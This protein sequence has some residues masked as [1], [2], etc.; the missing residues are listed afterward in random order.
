MSEG[1]YKRTFFYCSSRRST[2]IVSPVRLSVHS[3]QSSKIDRQA[4]QVYLVIRWF[5]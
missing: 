1:G 4:D 5:S 2:L 3:V